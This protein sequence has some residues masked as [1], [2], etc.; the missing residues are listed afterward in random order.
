M[1]ALGTYELT[2]IT[3]D[4]TALRVAVANQAGTRSLRVAGPDAAALTGFEGEA[5]ESEGGSLLVGP[6]S[7]A[8]AAA[9]HTHLD[10]TGVIINMMV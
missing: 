1:T 5:S 3:P 8:N 6:L 10:M 9:L 4:G 7:P 2:G